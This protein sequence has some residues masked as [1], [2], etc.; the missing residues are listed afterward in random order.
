MN[1]IDIIF[2]LLLLWG[3]TNGFIKG[4]VLQSL[5]LVA[6]VV[7]VWAGI[8]F[9]QSIGML[10]AK[11]FSVNEKLMNLISF[12]L[13]FI[14]VLIAM[15]FLSKLITRTM[16]KSTVGVLNRIGGIIFGIAKMAFII[17]VLIFIIQK[18]DPKEK[19]ISKNTKTK[20]VLFT[21]IANI[22]PAVFPHLHL[23]EIKDGLL[24]I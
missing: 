21:P 20:S 9:Y 17:S 3:A 1:T 18:F 15:Y 22:A 6:L 24:G 8:E 14:L 12:T 2:I 19:F 16:A 23:K 10:L 13:I 5:T 11:W 7:G 4:F